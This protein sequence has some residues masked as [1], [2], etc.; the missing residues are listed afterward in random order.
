MEDCFLWLPFFLCFFRSLESWYHCAI[1]CLQ[2]EYK[3]KDKALLQ[4]IASY[5]SSMHKMFI[6]PINGVFCW[7]I[8]QFCTVK[9]T[10]ILKALAILKIPPIKK[11]GGEPS[12]CNIKH[13]VTKQWKNAAIRQAS[14]KDNPTKD[15]R[16]SVPQNWQC[17]PTVQFLLPLT[18][19][20]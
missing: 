7:Q 5:I 4:F 1:L 15:V 20:L 9:F 12:V 16:T 13:L 2:T 6:G 19:S 11:K 10:Q 14:L 8:F 18:A 17:C 3:A